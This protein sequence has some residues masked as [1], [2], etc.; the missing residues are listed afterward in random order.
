MK[1]RLLNQYAKLIVQVGANVKK[2]DYVTI[3]AGIDNPDFILKVAQECYKSKASDVEIRWSFDEFDRL[4]IKNTSEKVLSKVEDWEIEKM[5][6]SVE[7]KPV[8]IY[9]ESMDPDALKGIDQNKYSKVRQTRGKIFK[10]YRDQME[11][12]YKWVIA[13]IPGEKWAKK[14]FPN[15]PTKQ[16]EDALFEAILKTSRAYEGNPNENWRIHNAN[17]LKHCEILNSLDIDH[18]EYTSSNGTNLTVGLIKGS[19]FE[20]GTET[21]IS[22]ETFNPNIPS[23]EVFTSPDR[24]RTNGIVYSSK[25]LSYNGEI[26]DKFYIRFKDGKAVES[27][28]EV[29]DELL[30]QLINMD[31]GSHYLGE[32]A[33]VPFTSPINKTGILFYNTL[34]DENAVCHLALGRGFNEPIEGYENMSDEELSNLGLNDSLIHVDFMIGTEDLKITAVTRSGERK[35][36]FEGNWLI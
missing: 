22:G 5:K 1:Q 32:C 21:T 30:K 10:P 31:E 8:M 25:P 11:N 9:I 35:V 7:R 20:A 13:A 15:L 12:K 4:R 19:K 33:I 3:V 24:T 17:L 36:I 14:V 18:L 23:E 28:A 29:N 6:L 26:I 16:A 27:H 34:F 2:G